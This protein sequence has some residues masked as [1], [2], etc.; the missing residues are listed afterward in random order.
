MVNIC[1]LHEVRDTASS[2]VVISRVYVSRS[3]F[4]FLSFLRLVYEQVAKVSFLELNFA[5]GSYFKAFG[6]RALCLHL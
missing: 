5:S 4:I 1:S 6:S 2:I 3:T